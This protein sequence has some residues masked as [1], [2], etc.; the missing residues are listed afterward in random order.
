M[1]EVK[2]GLIREFVET[3][4]ATYSAVYT[5][6]S[7][8]SELVQAMDVVQ[9]LLAVLDELV[10]RPAKVRALPGTERIWSELY[11]ARFG[12]YQKAGRK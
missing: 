3:T 8:A 5:P 4:K 7:E 12:H 9:D 1:E 10:D 2:L 6:G 11:A